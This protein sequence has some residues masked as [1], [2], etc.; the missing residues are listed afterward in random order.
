MRRRAFLTSLLG[1]AAAECTNRRSAL[2]VGGAGDDGRVIDVKSFGAKGDGRQIDLPATRAALAAASS[3]GRR[4]IFFPPGDYYLGDPAG[5]PLLVLRDRTELALTGR[6]ATLSCKSRQGI[7]AILRLEG[8]QAV[9]IEG[10]NFQ[11]RGLNRQINWLGAVAVELATSDLRGCEAIEVARCHFDSVLSAVTCKV[12]DYRTSA[13]RL[14][15]LVVSRSY[16]GFNFQNNGDHVVGRR[17]HC[18]DVKRAYFPY[19]VTDHDVQLVA[20]NNATRF[21]DVLLKC[22]TRETSD[23]RVQITSR[24]KKGGDCIV[25]LEQQHEKSQGVMRDIHVAL[26]AKISDC[27]VQNV[28]LIRALNAA[29]KVEAD[30]ASRWDNIF[31]DGNI[32]V[33]DAT[34]IVHVATKAKQVGHLFIGSRLAA[35]VRLPEVFPGFVT[36]GLAASGPH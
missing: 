2:A 1:I 19:G 26:D 18:N 14:T 5:A 22:Y 34:E 25:A 7:N 3:G 35:N 33:C 12:G 21:T 23:I 29:G 15:D 24:G 31:L 20:E 17:L 8:C 13:V 4:T 27:S 9:R 36:Q 11:D 30:T 6:D 32:E 16:Y 28:V 10:L